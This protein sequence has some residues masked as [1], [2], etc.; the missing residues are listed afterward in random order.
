[1]GRETGY[2]EFE[3]V[4]LRHHNDWLRKLLCHGSNRKRDVGA[5][6]IILFIGN[7]YVDNIGDAILVLS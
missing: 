6:Q 4:I 1:M 7:P 5:S 3:L 2:Y